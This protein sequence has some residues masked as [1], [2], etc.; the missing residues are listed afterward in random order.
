MNVVHRLIAVPFLFGLLSAGGILT[1]HAAA[2]T[3]SVEAMSGRTF[4]GEPHSKTD[5]I[6]L[7]IESRVGSTSVQRPVQWDRI[8]R[9]TTGDAVY[10]AN[11]FRS[12]LASGVIDSPY[13]PAERKRIVISGS[14][15]P[16]VTD[17]DRVR[18]LLTSPAVQSPPE[19]SRV[20]FAVQLGNWDRDIEMDGFELNLWL[21]DSSRRPVAVRGQ[22]D[23]VV[24]AIPHER[25][26]QRIRNPSAQLKRIGRWSQRME[27]SD[28]VA[29]GAHYELPWNP[30]Q[31]ANDSALSNYGVVVIR[32][33]IPGQGVI[34]RQIEGIRIREFSLIGRRN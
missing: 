19:V 6:V 11:Q 24:Y 15:I 16:S 26:N 31:I 29:G 17:A 28:F 33:G 12:R 25:L 14:R 23:V 1:A 9:V 32:V 7:W 34:E 2:A 20:G 27:V 13:Q 30:R 21:A 3:I 5:D 8:V 10:S 4:V 18:A 22:L